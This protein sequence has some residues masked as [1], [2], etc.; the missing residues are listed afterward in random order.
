MRNPNEPLEV[1]EARALGLADAFAGPDMAGAFYLELLR[2][3]A[4]A[5]VL[6]N[7]TT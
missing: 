7:R 4:R 3:E 6:R 2:V 1:D 5:L